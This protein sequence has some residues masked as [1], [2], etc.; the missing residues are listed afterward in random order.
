MREGGKEKRRSP[1]RKR[2]GHASADTI[3]MGQ[4][5][6]MPKKKPTNKRK[7]AC[8][9]RSLDGQSSFQLPFPSLALFPHSFSLL[10][11]RHRSLY[12]SCLLSFFFCCLRK[13]SFFQKKKK[14][15]AIFTLTPWHQPRVITTRSSFRTRYFNTHLSPPTR[16]IPRDW[17]SCWRRWWL[18]SLQLDC[19]DLRP[20]S[21]RLYTFNLHDISSLLKNH[22]KVALLLQLDPPLITSRSNDCRQR[23]GDDT[24]WWDHFHP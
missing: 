14:G 4:P 10:S 5:N 3:N 6:W 17:K 18:F 23:T 7:S 21:T 1:R 20:S 22:S 2:W 11:I 19:H 8:L 24:R 9:A 13:K 16:F 12:L 15:N